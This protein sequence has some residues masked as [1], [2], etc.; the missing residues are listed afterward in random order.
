[1]LAT[2]FFNLMLYNEKAGRGGAYSN[3]QLIYTYI[4]DV[5]YMHQSF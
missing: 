4:F 3:F 2:H 1:M 5:I